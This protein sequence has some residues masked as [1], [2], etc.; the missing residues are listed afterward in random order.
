MVLTSMPKGDILDKLGIDV[1]FALQYKI[2]L[3]IQTWQQ[4]FCLRLLSNM[5]YN[6]E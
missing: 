5:A 6:L 4:R 3:N 1:K 2:H